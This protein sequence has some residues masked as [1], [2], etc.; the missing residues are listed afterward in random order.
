MNRVLGVS[1]SVWMV[2]VAR[3]DF[4]RGSNQGTVE[5]QPG[6]VTRTKREG[7]TPRQT[8]SIQV[9]LNQCELHGEAYS[10]GAQGEGAEQ[11]FGQPSEQGWLSL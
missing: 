6:R 3:K 5:N 10:G 1:D 11:L 2:P 4:K 8:L 9:K 7:E